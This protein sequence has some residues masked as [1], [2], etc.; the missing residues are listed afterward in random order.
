MVDSFAKFQETGVLKRTGP[1]DIKPKM[2]ENMLGTTMMDF[3]S[4]ITQ[5]NDLKFKTVTK[6]KAY[7][8]KFYIF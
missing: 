2:F 5:T 1:R 7:L 8:Y 6:Y 3:L 4:D